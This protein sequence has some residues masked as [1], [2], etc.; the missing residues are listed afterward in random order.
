MSSIYDTFFD[1]NQP[2]PDKVSNCQQ[3]RK[4]YSDEIQTAR[5]ANCKSC[6]ETKIRVKY[7]EII[8]N[9]FVTSLR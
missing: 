1:F 4:Q 8:W 7:M 5:N 3:L 6:T 2:C 9:A